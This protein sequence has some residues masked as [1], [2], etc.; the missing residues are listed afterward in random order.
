[1][2]KTKTDGGVEYGK[3][4][5]LY[6][7]D[8]VPDH[9]KLRIKEVVDGKQE[10]TRAQLGRA[11]AA[12]SPGGFRGQ[13][14]DIPSADL[15]SVKA[16]LRS[17]YKS[18]DVQEADIPPHVLKESAHP[19]EIGRW[20]GE[21]RQR[22]QEAGA[23]H[24]KA[25]IAIIDNLMAGHDAMKGQLQ[26]LRRTPKLHPAAAAMKRAYAGQMQETMV[27]AD[28][29]LDQRI[30]D[31]RNAYYDSVSIDPMAHASVDQPFVEEV[32]DDHLIVSKGDDYV[33]IPYTMAADGT[34][35]FGEVSPVDP[36]LT[37]EPSTESMQEAVVSGQG[38]AHLLEA[39]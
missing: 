28:G 27:H 33:T 2:N 10:V 26:T 25:E 17:L 39:K 24:T 18:L 37:Y 32:F 4:A 21:Y 14:V 30:C 15:P 5:Y 38:D 3:D 9:W 16:K 1:M 36:K 29:S 6:T 35:T 31:V 12:L 34:V 22:L 23:A 7:P 20:Y 8:D 19:E 13:T 11:A